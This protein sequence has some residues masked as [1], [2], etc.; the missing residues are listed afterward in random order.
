[1]DLGSNRDRS[2]R[3]SRD[4]DS[5]NNKITR[6]ICRRMAACVVATTAATTVVD[7]T[8]KEISDNTDVTKGP[9]GEPQV[10]PIPLPGPRPDEDEEGEEPSASDLNDEAEVET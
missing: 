2:A 10:R 5:G 6:S 7:N 8:G 4:D 1:M 3:G 9:E